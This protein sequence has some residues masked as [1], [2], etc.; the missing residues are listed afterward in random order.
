MVQQRID[1]S[2]CCMAWRGMNHETGR[3]IYH[4]DVLVF[5]DHGERNIFGEERCLTHRRNHEVERLPCNERGAGTHDEAPHGQMAL[6]DESLHKRAREPTPICDKPVS[7]LP[8]RLWRD[9][10]I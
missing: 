7:T 9:R 4:H 6:R 2:A 8:G 5:V 3:L 10:Q 1:E